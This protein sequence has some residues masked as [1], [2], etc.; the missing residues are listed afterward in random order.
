V[1]DGFE[2]VEKVDARQQFA[3]SC[4]RQRLHPETSADNLL[5]LRIQELHQFGN[6][7]AGGCFGPPA[8]VVV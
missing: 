2:G 3:Q 1:G 5:R 6:F 7:V 4:I 8:W